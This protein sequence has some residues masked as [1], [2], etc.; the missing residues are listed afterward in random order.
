MFLNSQT[1]HSVCVCV[2]VCVCLT[3]WPEQYIRIVS[4]RDV[5]D[6]VAHPYRYMPEGLN[7]LPIEG[8]EDPYDLTI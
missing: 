1:F 6:I 2:C 5:V 8:E 7:F 4:L 3:T